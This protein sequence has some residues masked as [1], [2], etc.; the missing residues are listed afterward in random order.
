MVA[1]IAAVQEDAAV[2]AVNHMDDTLSWA[3]VAPDWAAFS[4]AQK[5]AENMMELE[6]P[7]LQ[8]EN[9]KKASFVQ[10]DELDVLSSYETDNASAEVVEVVATIAAVQEDAAVEAVAEVP[11]SDIAKTVVAVGVAAK[12]EAVAVVRFKNLPQGLSSAEIVTK[13][14]RDDTGLD[15]VGFNLA[16]EKE[17]GIASATTSI[18]VAEKIRTALNGKPWNTRIVSGGLYHDK[19]FGHGI[20]LKNVPIFFSKVDVIKKLIQVGVQSELEAQVFDNNQL[21]KLASLYERYFKVHSAGTFYI[22][23]SPCDEE[24]A[25]TM[26]EK[27]VSMQHKNWSTPVQV[28]INN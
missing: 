2:E 7:K 8:H 5:L 27:F 23:C 13:R 16:Y 15:L 9:F 3:G 21:K 26:L 4:I 10:K 18:E 12:F 11:A 19:K 17:T 6:G 28:F 20:R 14:L 1:T 22:Y 25:K 24:S